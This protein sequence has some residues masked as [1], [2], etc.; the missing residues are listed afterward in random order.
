MGK[1]VGL[2]PARMESTRFPGKPIIDIYGLPMVVRVYNQAK[3][4][5]FLD[6]VFIC[7]DSEIIAQTAK[8]HNCMVLLTTS[9]PQNGTERCA[10][11]LELLSE[12]F[13]YIVNIQGDE[14]NIAPQQIEQ[15]CKLL[16][17]NQHEIVTLGIE[18]K[19]KQDFTQNNIVKA[20]LDENDFA[21]DF[22]RNIEL[23][24]ANKIFKHIGIYGFKT[25]ILKSI[26]KMKPTS[27]ETKKSL[28]QIRW[29]DNG[30]DIKIG[31]TDF[32]SNAVDLPEDIQKLKKYY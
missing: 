32:E 7:T 4:C 24:G 9:K 22:E 21:I 31:I 11:A 30:I 10:E 25:A 29:L 16:A 2:I 18:I 19:D 13:D 5:T 8:E 6:E 26:V 3:K 12:T 14:P 27:N 15:I 17:E 28:E 20:I 1:I 23:K